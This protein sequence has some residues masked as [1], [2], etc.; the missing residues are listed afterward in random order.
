MLDRPRTWRWAAA[1]GV[2]STSVY[3]VGD[4]LEPRFAD[5]S[6][7]LAQSYYADLFL[8]HD[9]RNTGWFEYMALD[10]PPLPKYVIGATLRAAGHPRPGPQS[11]RDWYHNP[12]LKVGSD[13]DLLIARLPIALFGALGC[14]SAFGL[15]CMF[16]DRRAGLLAAIL[17]LIDP[18]YR[19]HA[20]RAMSDVPCESLVLATA[21]LALSAW[22]SLLA[23]RWP[24]SLVLLVAMASGATAG[25]AVLAKLSGGLAVIIISCWTALA[26]CLPGFAWGRKM[27]VAGFA[28]IVGVVSFLTFAALNPTLWAMPEGP[29]TAEM[30]AFA[31]KSIWVRAADIIALRNEVGRN[32]QGP[33]G[34]FRLDNAGEKIAAVAVQGYGRFGPFGPQVLNSEQR[35]DGIRDL[36][37][38][39]WAP[40]V[41]LG[42][43]WAAVRGL[44]QFR[45]REPPAAWALLVQAVVALT[46]VT[47]FIPLAWD[48][49]FLPIEPVSIVLASGVAV[50]AYD[51][52]TARRLRNRK[53]I[54]VS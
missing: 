36:G 28:L 45:Q 5:E 21:F 50:T 20:S 30:R 23:G 1:V 13:V 18:L 10:L 12:N 15:A 37:T 48:R 54:V 46:T 51:R 16:K 52:V 43:V 42:M 31:R 25:L 44:E 11:A 35:Y 24:V 41:L 19:V 14:V 7:Y 32:I 4:F 49:Y 39:I 17:L 33:L 26:A 3:L 27:A 2:L 47:A 9:W 53:E 29:M 38:L 6:A 34:R 8:G 22:R 40:W